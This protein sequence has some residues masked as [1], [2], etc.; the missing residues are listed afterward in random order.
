MRNFWAWLNA[1]LAEPSS[2]AG[3]SGVMSGGAM[4]FEKSTRILG[5]A[6]ILSGLASIFKPDK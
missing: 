2:L 4:L 6:A 5:Y 1:R 3:I